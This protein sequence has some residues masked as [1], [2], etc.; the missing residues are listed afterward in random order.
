MA[1][2]YFN[3]VLNTSEISDNLVLVSNKQKILTNSCIKAVAIR[4]VPAPALFIKRF[5]RLS[6][7]PIPR[8]AVIGKIINMGLMNSF[9]LSDGIATVIVPKTISRI[10]MIPNAL[11]ASWLIKI[12]KITVKIGYV[13]RSVPVIL[14]SPLLIT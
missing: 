14:N 10:A 9:V 1:N 11:I 12:E 5:E 7:K 6:L 13:E 8:A 2:L 3:G 4:K